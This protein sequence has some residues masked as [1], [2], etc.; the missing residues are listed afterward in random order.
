MFIFQENLKKSEKFDSIEPTHNSSK[1][2]FIITSKM[3]N[4]YIST[5][6]KILSFISR[7][8]ERF[9][10]SLKVFTRSLTFEE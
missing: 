8:F 5:S 2:K 6:E 10:L 9:A 4:D 1:A 3:A 7:L